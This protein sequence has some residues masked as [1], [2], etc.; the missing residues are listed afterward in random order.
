ML[1]GVLEEIVHDNFIQ[2]YKKISSLLVTLFTAVNAHYWFALICLALEEGHQSSKLLA[3][4]P[5]PIT[6][7]FDLLASV[8]IMFFGYLECFIQFVRLRSEIQ[9]YWPQL[10]FP[11]LVF[12]EIAE[13][14]RL[15]NETIPTLVSSLRL[16]IS[17][18]MAD[19]V[20]SIVVSFSF[21]DLEEEEERESWGRRTW[22]RPW[23]QFVE[24]RRRFLRA[25]L[26]SVKDWV[27]WVWS[28][29]ADWFNI[30]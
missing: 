30:R 15:L 22:L 2:W 4:F 12:Q 26:K 24:E 25:L 18:W 9:S 13:S 7:V 3:T 8:L 29:R 1:V 28:K 5:Q 17:C 14:P 20:A 21:V 11:E 6:I 23:F 19:R 10:W 16:C 27:G